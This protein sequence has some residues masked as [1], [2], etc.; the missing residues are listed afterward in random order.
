MD[1]KNIVSEVRRAVD[2]PMLIH[3]AGSHSYGMATETSDLDIRGVYCA[4]RKYHTPFF[5]NY[6]LSVPSLEDAKLYEIAKYLKLYTEGNP[7][8]LESLWV[9]YEDI[10]LDSPAYRELRLQ[11][12]KL[13]SAKVAFTFSGYAV[14]QLNRIKGHGRWLSNPQP[15]DPPRQ[16][17]F[18]KLVQNF[19]PQKKFSRDFEEGDLFNYFLVPYGGISTV[20]LDM[21]ATFR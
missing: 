2:Q 13:L 18:I 20:R 19:L 1:V 21:M 10:I 16:A 15:V 17:T 14:S 4:E 12:E 5:N 6:E 9:S 8:I 11:R 7:N 3:V